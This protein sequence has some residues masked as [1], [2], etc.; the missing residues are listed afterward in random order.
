MVG[1]AQGWVSLALVSG[2]GKEPCAGSG[3]NG[4]SPW[5]PAVVNVIVNVLLL[6][7]LILFD[8]QQFSFYVL[9]RYYMCFFTRLGF[10]L[11]C[12]IVARK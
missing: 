10:F 7:K 11:T 5:E 12:A 3:G 2:Q 4:T 1:S 9:T 8:R 6:F